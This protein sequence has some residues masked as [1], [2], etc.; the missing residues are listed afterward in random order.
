MFN[1]LL[2]TKLAFSHEISCY[3]MSSLLLFASA[4]CSW[5]TLQASE[6]VDFVALPVVTSKILCIN[7]NTAYSTYS[8]GKRH[9]TFDIH[10]TQ[11]G[12]MTVKDHGQTSPCKVTPNIFLRCHFG[13]CLFMYLSSHGAIDVLRRAWRCS[14]C[15]CTCGPHRNR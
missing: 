1:C 11:K 12:H 3:F 6:R 9:I 10:C 14:F 5:G 7:S 13:L 8:P 4:M 2:L 15:A